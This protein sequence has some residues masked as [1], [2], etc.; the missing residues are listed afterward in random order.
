MI[1]RGTARLGRR[2]AMALGLVGLLAWVLPAQR[3]PMQESLRLH[4][5]LAATPLEGDSLPLVLPGGGRGMLFVPR[6][7]ARR[8]RQHL[9]LHFHGAP[10]LVR[11]AAAAQKPGMTVA[12]FSLGSGSGVYDRSFRE[13]GAMD[14]VMAQVQR[15]LDSLAGRTVRIERVVL[16]GFSAGH[17]AIRVILRDSTWAARVHA[18][19]LLD[20]MH[21]SYVPEGRP[22]AD[23]G[24]LDSL[25]LLSLTA[26]AR[27][28]VNGQ[29]RML[30][31]HSEI[32][33][34]TY[35]S[36][37]ETAQWMLQALGLR[38]KPVLAWG[39]RGMQQ[40]SDTRAGRLRVMG[41]AGT[42]APDHIDHLH[43]MP[44]LLRLLLR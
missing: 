14:S 27:R 17:G 23:G 28:A 3:S 29:S 5:R 11:Q 4:A 43:A 34:G 37:T 30:V 33:P 40:L 21:T 44:E 36:T 41:F 24:T 42:S 9:L 8:D 7:Q 10:W 19:L 2:T 18:V 13:P 32:F 15:G 31:T 39:P 1:G 26:F 38:A 12:T 22:L 35:A 16:S 6:A 25:N 20:G